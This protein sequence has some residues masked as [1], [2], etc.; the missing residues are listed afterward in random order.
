MATTQDYNAVSQGLDSITRAV[1]GSFMA[2]QQREQLTAEEKRREQERA[3]RLAFQAWQQQ[4]REKQRK[5][6]EQAAQD[7]AAA[8]K[9]QEQRLTAQEAERVRAGRLKEQA[10]QDAAGLQKA[11]MQQFDPAVQADPRIAPTS[12][13]EAIGATTPP[14]LR[15]ENPAD[16]MQAAQRVP[17]SLTPQQMVELAIRNQAATAKN[18][19]EAFRP[20]PYRFTL[21]NG[22]TVDGYMES[23]NQFKAVVNGQDIKAYAVNGP[24]G[25]PVP[26]LLSINGQVERIKAEPIPDGKAITTEL[27]AIEDWFAANPPENRR[28]SGAADLAAYYTARKQLLMRQGLGAAAPAPGGTPAPAAAGTPPQA[29][30]PAASGAQF[31]LSAD[32]TVSEGGKVLIPGTA[33]PP[34]DREQFDGNPVADPVSVQPAKPEVP[35]TPQL[36]G[37]TMPA[38]TTPPPN[39]AGYTAERAARDRVTSL[40]AEIQTAL[41]R[42]AEAQAGKRG[43]YMDK[44]AQA[45]LYRKTMQRVQELQKLDPTAAAPFLQ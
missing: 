41:T 13:D 16:L 33:T 14:A 24:D 31:K 26:N 39:R 17:G 5:L 36:R 23:P 10:A 45:D 29:A 8:R 22:Q 43:S 1:L 3:D 42:L 20:V 34:D 21:A 18:G 2:R 12:Y 6:Q 19:G 15:I 37:V 44:T 27:Q 25:K 9:A 32:G 35:S 7:A 38:I 30:P 40:S 4:D 11:F 28:G